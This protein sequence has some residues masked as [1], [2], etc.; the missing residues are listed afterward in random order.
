MVF[1]KL[2]FSE[3]YFDFTAAE[4]EPSFLL[5]FLYE[6]LTVFHLVLHSAT[7]IKKKHIP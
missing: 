3:E 4:I 6:S 5:L 7:I 2:S 1:K